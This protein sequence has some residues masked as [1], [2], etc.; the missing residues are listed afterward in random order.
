[1][2]NEQWYGDAKKELGQDVAAAVDVPPVP[3][4]VPF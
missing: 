2:E 1:M 3:E 4:E